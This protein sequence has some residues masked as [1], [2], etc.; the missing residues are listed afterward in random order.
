MNEMRRGNQRQTHEWVTLVSPKHPLDGR[1]IAFMPVKRK[2]EV[3]EL[4]P[5][6]RKAS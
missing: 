4:R 5:P 2:A 1:F 6:M 3:I